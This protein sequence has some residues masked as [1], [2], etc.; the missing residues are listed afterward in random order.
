MLSI[1]AMAEIF[2]KKD[3]TLD[4]GYENKKAKNLYTL[5]EIKYYYINFI[6]Y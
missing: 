5:C 1:T 3:V 2:F 6:L 4:N